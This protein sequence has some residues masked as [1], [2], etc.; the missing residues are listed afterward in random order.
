MAADGLLLN[1][2]D[3]NP[4]EIWKAV[5]PF[6]RKKE[7]LP[8]LD[9]VTDCPRLPGTEGFPAFSANTRK[10]LASPRGSQSSARDFG[11]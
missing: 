5:D 9:R 3:T 8:C 6:L 10:V 11:P 1:L 2:W 4:F 7:S